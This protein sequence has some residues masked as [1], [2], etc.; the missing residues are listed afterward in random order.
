MS[1]AVAERNWLLR[2]R[3]LGMI[4]AVT[5]ERIPVSQP[6]VSRS[7]TGSAPEWSKKFEQSVHQIL[8]LGADWDNRGSS[9]PRVD[10]LAFAYSLLS[11][12][13]SPMTVAPSVIPMSNGGVQ[14]VWAGSQVDVEVEVVQPNE[15]LVYFV[16]RYSGTENEWRLTTEF[17]LLSTL[18]RS[19]FTPVSAPR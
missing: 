14:L 10:A 1:Y 11:Q 4:D 15:A 2:S 17:S 3:P 9:A 8:E 12:A 6:A 18:L 13:M 19:K 5:I 7:S 16:D